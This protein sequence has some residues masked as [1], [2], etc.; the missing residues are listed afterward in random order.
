MTRMGWCV[1]IRDRASSGKDV[2]WRLWNAM[3]R[4]A[5]WLA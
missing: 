2:A 3:K 4:Y 1:C 5:L